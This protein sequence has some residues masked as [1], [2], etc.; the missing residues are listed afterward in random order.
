MEDDDNESEG[1]SIDDGTSNSEED[2]IIDEI[3][4]AAK[5]LNGSESFEEWEEREAPDDNESKIKFSEE[6]AQKIMFM[7][8]NNYMSSKAYQLFDS[9]VTPLSKIFNLE[10]S[11]THYLEEG[12][13]DPDTIINWYTEKSIKI[14]QQNNDLIKNKKIEI[15]FVLDRSYSMEGCR[16]VN[17]SEM[18]SALAHAFE[19]VGVPTSIYMFDGDSILVKD[20]K[21]PVLLDADGRSSIVQLF[22]EYPPNGSTDPTDAFIDIVRK[23]DLVDSDVASVL[24]FITDGELDSRSC[25]KIVQDS[26][27][28]LTAKEWL[29]IPVGI[30]FSTK[31]LENLQRYTTPAT[32]KRYRSADL[33]NVLGED[34]ANEIIENLILV[35]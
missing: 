33:I 11:V 17:M 23:A 30:D 31:E 28:E 13:I 32:A 12:E 27:E 2:E 5:S 24:I 8:S 34:I 18:V 7:G 14:F 16:F 9:C 4:Q 29:V 1:G 10:N 19:E 21:T 35:K 26:I 20:F 3:E 15:T 22:D 6:E 25:E